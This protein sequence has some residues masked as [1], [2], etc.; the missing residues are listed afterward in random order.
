MDFQCNQNTT[1]PST[2]CQPKQNQPVP[3]SECLKVLSVICTHNVQEVAQLTLPAVALGITTLPLPPITFTVNPNGIVLRGTLLQDKV[4]NTGFV[5][6]TITVGPL[7]TPLLTI[8]VNL[9]FQTEVECPGA[10][11]G[12]DLQK[13]RPVV[14][15]VLEPFFTPLA[16]VVAGVV[17]IGTFTFKAILRTQVTV[18]REK[19]VQGVFNVIG[20]LNPDRCVTVQPTIPSSPTQTFFGTP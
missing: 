17:G 20:D 8:N 4:V 18:S 3:Q 15:G 14:E 1:L 11:P 10:C 16:E 9:P 13:T 5:P 19:L 6:A 2:C 7:A 12:D